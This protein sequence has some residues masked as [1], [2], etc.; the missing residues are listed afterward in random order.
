[1]R[2]TTASGTAPIPIPN[3]QSVIRVFSNPVITWT[4]T[5]ILLFSAS[6]Q[7]LQATNPRQRK[8]QINN[9]LHALM[10]TLMAA[11]V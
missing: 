1:M 10:H 11:M 5:A 4:L 8:D 2:S 9:S 7:I 3:N 6:H